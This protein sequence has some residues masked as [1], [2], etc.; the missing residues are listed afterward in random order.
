MLRRIL[1][2]G[3]TMLLLPGAVQTASLSFQIVDHGVFSFDTGVLKGQLRADEHSQGI[4]TMVDLASGVELAYGGSNPGIFSYYRMFSAGTRYADTAR[5]LPKAA[6]LLDDG[7]V[8]ID[9]PAG[10]ENPFEMTAVYRWSA[11][12]ILDLETRV[13]PQ[14]DMEDFEIFLSS[15]FNENFRSFV[16]THPA[17]YAELGA[18][19]L[20]VDVNPL[21]YGTYVAFPRDLEAAQIVY[22]GRWEL[23]QHPVQ[24]SITQ[25]YEVPLCIKRNLEDGV[26]FV[27]MSP[28]DDCFAIETPYNME[29]PDNVAAHYSLYMSLFG[30]DIAAGMTQ[31]AR[32]RFVFERNLAEQHAVDLYEEYMTFI[33]QLPK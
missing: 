13:T 25:Y 22:D 15:Y 6:K 8:R 10:E 29:P 32:T 24:F 11:P 19:F 7:S 2:I 28:T 3:V 9:W 4:P 26:A 23:G 14:I 5:T 27:M 20:P 12:N 33:E 18:S 30:I 1:F 21:I 31:T 16:Y 17:R